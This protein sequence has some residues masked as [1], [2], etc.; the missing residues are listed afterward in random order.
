MKFRSIKKRLCLFLV[1]VAAFLNFGA[2]KKEKSA[3]EI[4][5]MAKNAVGE[6]TTYDQS[7]NQY[8]LGSCFAYDEQGQIMTNYHVIKGAYSAKVAINGKEYTA[9]K[10]MAYNKKID[11][12]VLKIDEKNLPVLKMSQEKQSVGDTVY[13]L[14]SSQGLTSTFS[15]GIISYEDREIDGVHYIQHNAAISSGNSG[16]ALINK[17]G[18][19]IG[20]NT[21]SVRDSQNLNFAI[22]CS[23]FFNLEEIEPLTF[24]QYYEKEWGTFNKI[25]NYVCRYGNYQSDDSSYKITFDIKTISGTD[26]MTSVIYETR[27]ELLLFSVLA[28]RGRISTLLS[29]SLDSLDEEYYW[30]YVDVLNQF[31]QGKVRAE[32]W[33]RTSELSYLEYSD[34]ATENLVETVR[35]VSASM[36][37][38]LLSRMKTDFWRIGLSAKDIGFVN[39]E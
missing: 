25:K 31:M 11:L 3:E 9:E 26:Y 38:Y 16:G 35:K 21:M 22:S 34:I 23:E 6:I 15:S 39:F 18:E 17:Y 37:N 8:A 30:A 19:I 32:L 5:E 27:E 13:A 20:V 4:Y 33:T 12:A 10:I 29:L 1:V 2:C 14:G 7:G 28:V 36:L 24:A